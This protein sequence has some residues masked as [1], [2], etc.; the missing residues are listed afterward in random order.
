MKILFVTTSFPHPKDYTAGIYNYNRARALVALGHDVLVL[1]FNNI[2]NRHFNIKWMKSYST[3]DFG[4]DSNIDVRCVNYL[5]LASLSDGFVAR[6][7]AKIVGDWKADIV[8]FHFLWNALPGPL[9]KSRYGIPYLI[10]GHGSDVNGI[11]RFSISKKRRSLAALNAAS[12]VIFVSAALQKI[13]EN[14]GFTGNA[15]V[16]SNGIDPTIFRLPAVKKP[17]T[18]KRIGFVGW[19]IPVKRAEVLADIF[20]TMAH[21]NS[22]LEFVVV[23]SGHLRDRVETQC[24]SYQLQ[25]RFTGPLSPQEV[26]LEMQQFDL[27]ILPSRSEGWPCVVIEAQ[28]CGVPVVGSAVGGIPEAVGTGGQIVKD[29][30][31]F[32]NRFASACMDQLSESIKPNVLSERSAHYSW[33]MLAIKELDVYQQY[34]QK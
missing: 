22:D 20:Q 6:H 15:H 16:I 19:L 25:A 27:L 11:P 32:I 8:H 5:R 34:A 33:A 21:Q 26:A 9:L 31:D 12:A 10:T 7:I 24:Q 29:G 1:H 18:V 23:G 13:A 30:P 17:S 3:Q 2:I 14:N 4:L 28:A